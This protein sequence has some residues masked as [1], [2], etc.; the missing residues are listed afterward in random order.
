[1]TNTTGITTREQTIPNVNKTSKMISSPI[2]NLE[3]KEKVKLDSFELRKDE[4]PKSINISNVD[5]MH[6]IVAEIKDPSQF[7]GLTL[8]RRELPQELLE[9]K[10]MQA[11]LKL[12]LIENPSSI[13]TNDI[14]KLLVYTKNCILDYFEDDNNDGTVDKT[15]A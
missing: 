5:A 6:K 15:A 2:Q 8:S 3:P 10:I 1:M 9:E 13:F 7:L 12:P 11:F 14:T 4:L